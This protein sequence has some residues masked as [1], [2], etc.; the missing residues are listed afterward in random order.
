MIK[1]A[2]QVLHAAVLD[3]KIDFVRFLVGDLEVVVDEEEDG[4]TALHFAIFTGDLPMVQYLLD[5]GAYPYRTNRHGD[6][7]LHSAARWDQLEVVECLLERGFN[8]MIDSVNEYGRTP[9]HEAASRGHAEVV[10]LLMEWAAKLDVRTTTGR[11]PIDVAANE[12]IKQL[13]RDEEESRSNPAGYKRA[14][15]PNP[16]PAEEEAIKRARLGDD[17]EG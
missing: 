6:T 17:N 13:I 9:L 8:T 16:K 10:T 15:I 12:A 3:G 14:V 5:E 11:L 2:V 1:S 4:K 7:Y